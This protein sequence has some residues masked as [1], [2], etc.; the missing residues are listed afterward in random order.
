M[1]VYLGFTRLGMEI[2]SN[3][4]STLTSDRSPNSLDK[5][6]ICDI[7]IVYRYQAKETEIVLFELDTKNSLEIL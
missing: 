5:S 2:I 7:K 4:H 6:G 1:Y 3:I